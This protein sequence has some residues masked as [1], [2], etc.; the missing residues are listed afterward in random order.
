MI[1]TR[2]ISDYGFGSITVDG[3]TCNSDVIITP[4]K[5]V[6]G[7][8]RKQGHSLAV[9][10]LDEIVNAKPDLLIIGTGYHGRMQ[11]PDETRTFLEA[12]GIEIRQATTRD[13]VTEFNELQKKYARIVAALHLTC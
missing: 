8:W 3:E 7:W 11:V 2:H 6:D 12:H 13:A 9:D 1:A 4:E 10:D 5:V